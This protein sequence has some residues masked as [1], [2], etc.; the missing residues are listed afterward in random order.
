MNGERGSF[1][2]KKGMIIAAAGSAIGLGNIWRFPYVVGENGGAAFILIYL[3]IVFIIGLPILMSEFAMGRKTSKNVFGTF[4][5]LAPKTAWP[6]VGVL[7]ILTSL[8]VLAFYNVVSGWTLSFLS[9]SVMNNFSG[10]TSSEISTNFNSF[11][12]SGFKPVI[13]VAIFII[14]SVVI[15]MSGIEKGIEKYNKILMPMLFGILIILCLNSLTL[16]GFD[17]AMV[18]LFKPDFSKITTDVVLSALGQAFFS[19]SLGMGTMMTYGSYMRKDN[20]MVTTAM[21]VII[22]DISIAILAGIAIFPAVFSHGIEPTSGADL[23]FKTL[24][25]IFGNMTG[26]YIV[27][28]MFFMLLVVAAV[29]SAISLL[30]VV[31]AYC[32]EEVKVSRK[33]A[34]AGTALLVFVLSAL[35]ALSMMPNSVLRVG[36]SNLF[37]IFDKGS[38]LYM[39]PIGGFF[40]ALF[41]GWF[42]QKGVLKKELSSD[43]LYKVRYW[44]LFSFVMRYIAPVAILIIFI[45]SFGLF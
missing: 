40:V 18:F 21:Y 15:V 29:T 24:P 42:M 41:A 20:E 28:V 12:T 25:A 26:G 5:E 4:R 19:L 22:A 14:I 32:V 45:Y 17:Q 35:S 44:S 33:K 1:G 27:G 2:S 10:L 16:S 7:G 38:S 39:L 31:V 6:L 23:V 3:L 9:D 34:V 30:E 37:D 36:D 8:A 43:G 13:F 11:I